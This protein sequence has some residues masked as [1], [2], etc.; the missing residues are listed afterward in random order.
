MKIALIAVLG[1][2]IAGPSFAAGHAATTP[3]TA[4][5][6]RS[7]SQAIT[8]PASTCGQGTTICRQR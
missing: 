8:K 7:N 4:S 3:A 1:L 6:P 2:L 5:Q